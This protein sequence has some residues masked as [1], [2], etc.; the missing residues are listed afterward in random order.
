MGPHSEIVWRMAFLNSC[1]PAFHAE[2][3]AQVNSP[4]TGEEMHGSAM[5]ERGLQYGA[6]CSGLTI[7]MHMPA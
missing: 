2:S 7:M 3:S 1:W 4:V 5:E 6:T